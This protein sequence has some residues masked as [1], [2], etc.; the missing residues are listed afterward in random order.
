MGNR[1]G[2]G[3]LLSSDAAATDLAKGRYFGFPPYIKYKEFCTKKSYK[4]FSDLKEHFY[5]EV[6]ELLF[7]QT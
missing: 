7:Y 5:P 2:G 4:K 3:H 6:I 1:V